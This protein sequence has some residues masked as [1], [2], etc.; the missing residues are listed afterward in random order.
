MKLLMKLLVLLRKVYSLP[1][2]KQLLLT[3]V[4]SALREAAVRTDNK[5][6]DKIVTALAAALANENYRAV[7]NG[8]GKYAKII[9][10]AE[11]ADKKA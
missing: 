11:K 9:A 8:K 7:L 6:D 2:F 5:V 3:M 1:G 10:K 4:M